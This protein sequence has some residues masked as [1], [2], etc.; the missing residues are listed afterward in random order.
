MHLQFDNLVNLQCNQVSYSTIKFIL[1]NCTI[2]FNASLICQAFLL[3]EL[4]KPV[5]LVGL[6]FGN[7]VTVVGYFGGQSVL[8]HE[9]CLRFCFFSSPKEV[10]IF[11]SNVF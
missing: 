4:A 10:H 5:V 2:T 8:S 3:F 6:K 9:A 1:F 7:S 11:L